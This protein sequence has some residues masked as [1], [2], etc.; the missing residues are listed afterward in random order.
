MAKKFLCTWQTQSFYKNFEKCKQQISG[1]KQENKKNMNF[2]FKFFVPKFL[3]FNTNKKWNGQWKDTNQRIEFLW[4]R[5]SCSGVD[6]YRYLVCYLIKNCHFKEINCLF[7]LLERCSWNTN[8][9][10]PRIYFT[11]VYQSFRHMAQHN[12]FTNFFPWNFRLYFYKKNSC[13]RESSAIFKLN[14]INFTKCFN[15]IYWKCVKAKD[16]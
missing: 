15:F 13:Q 1:K 12:L 3:H 2:Q 7:F 4:G 10:F 5:L 9:W 14:L 8:V 6:S 16:N 11:F